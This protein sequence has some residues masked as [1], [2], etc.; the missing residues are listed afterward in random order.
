MAIEKELNNLNED[1]PEYNDIIPPPPKKKGA[2]P[3]T[4]GKLDR[5]NKLEEEINIL[6][7]AV[8]R[9]KLIEAEQ[10]ASGKKKIL[11]RG[12]LKKLQGKVVVAWLGVNDKGSSAKQEIIYNGSS[13]VG[14]RMIGH[15]KTIF[16]DD[17]VCDML[18][19]TRSTEKENFDIIAKNGE[20]LTICFDN[21]E[22]PSEYKINTKFINP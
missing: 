13:P 7:Q 15:Y 5:L 12:F 14:E 19:F 18:E 9:N 3:K 2:P 16:G 17:I 21:Q 6:R 10:K 20:E 11:G 4:G 1:I 22:L 8:S